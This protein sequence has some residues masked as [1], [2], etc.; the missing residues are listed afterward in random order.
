MV[1]ATA[2]HLAST[3]RGGNESRGIAGTQA[4]GCCSPCMRHVDTQS[5]AMPA[6]RM[7]HRHLEHHATHTAPPRT[8]LGRWLHRLRLY[9]QG[10][11]SL[12]LLE[13]WHGGVASKG[14]GRDGRGRLPCCSGMVG[15]PPK[16]VGAGPGPGWW[17]NRSGWVASSSAAR[18]P[19][20]T[21]SSRAPC[22]VSASCC[23]AA[24]SCMR[25]VAS[26]GGELRCQLLR[27]LC[28][29]CLLRLCGMQLLFVLRLP[30]CPPLRAQPLIVA[31]RGVRRPVPK[32]RALQAAHGPGGHEGVPAARGCCVHACM[33]CAGRYAMLGSASGHMCM[34]ALHAH[35]P[36][37]PRLALAMHLLHALGGRDGG[38]TYVSGT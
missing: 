3:A 2:A 25:V 10:R 7:L 30:F 33:E 35:P 8:C 23:C 38:G 15:C 31:R 17:P 37:P 20:L 16:A 22:R 32:A 28:L 21:A 18:P 14:G 24:V 29:R 5:T 36:A 27:A 26:C 6:A 9:E 11:R 1:A 12:L 4:A 34:A 13:R 19:A